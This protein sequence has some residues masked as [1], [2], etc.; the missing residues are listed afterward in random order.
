[1]FHSVLRLL[2]GFTKAALIAWKL[3]V[4]RVISRAPK[5]AAT[6]IHQAMVE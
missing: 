5:P 4:S 1:M 3:T 2:A 6:K